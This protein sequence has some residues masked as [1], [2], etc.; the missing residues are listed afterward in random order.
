MKILILYT[1]LTDYWMACMQH[2]RDVYDNKFL[3]FRYTPNPEAPFKIE[4]EN[5]IEIEDHEN[6]DQSELK[7]AIERF[8]PDLIYVAGWTNKTYLAI[9]RQYKNH[10]VSVV[11][12]MD[13]HW[14]ATPKQ[15]LASLLSHLFIHPYFTDIWI[16]GSAQYA[17]AQK[18]GFKETNIHT[19]LYCA[20][21]N[22]F[23]GKIK[24]SKKDEVVFIGRLVDHKGVPQFIHLLEKLIR[25]EALNIHIHFI[26]NG[27]L[28]DKIPQHR[29]IKH[30][31]FVKPQEL[32]NVLQK[33]GFLILPSSY[34]A[35]GVVVQ[36]ALLTGTPVISTYQC[37]AAVDLVEHK[38]NGFLFD[39]RNGL[40]LEKI[41]K[42]I[43][44]LSN[45]S[46]EAMS[47]NA[48]AA[49]KRIDHD[50]WSK[51]LEKIGKRNNA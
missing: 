44:E 11:T 24:K 20:N 34:E 27:P 6:Y 28:A 29:N 15:Y 18:L 38:K 19:G 2:S 43:K 13:N 23:R 50:A 40:Q 4:S 48:L 35:W 46:Y 33:T 7:K 30:T 42:N 45:E 22:L 39:S 10:G 26:G 32:P 41:L 14:K 9:A 51:T 25:E 49:A 8:A 3:V 36:E 31:S 5:G 17:F 1:R 21:T 16:P 12:G 47:K 37:G